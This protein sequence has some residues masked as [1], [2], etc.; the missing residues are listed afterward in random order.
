MQPEAEWRFFTNNA[1]G[2]CVDRA[3]GLCSGSE[4]DL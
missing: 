2:R 1:M 4:P 3:S